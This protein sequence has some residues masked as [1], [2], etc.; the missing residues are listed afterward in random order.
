MKLFNKANGAEGAK[1]EK[2]RSS[3]ALKRGVY[4]TAI[5][6]LFI[7]AV[8]LVNVLTTS[9]SARFPLTIDFSG[10]K[11]NSISE[12][13]AEYLKNVAKPVTIYVCATREEYEQ[14]Y[15]SQYAEYYYSVQDNTGKYY[16]QTLTLLD[17]YPKHNK[18]ITLEF[19]DMSS[20]ENGDIQALFTEQGVNYGDLLVA[21]SFVV[22]GNPVNRYK[23][24]SFSDIYNLTDDSG[25]AAM[26]FGSYGIGGSNLETAL[27]NAIYYATSERIVK[28]GI[29][30]SHCDVNN[31]AYLSDA[32]LA[33]NY[34]LLDLG[35]SLLT[36][37]PEDLDGM[38][39]AAPSKDFG[40]EELD[41]IA[42]FLDNNGKRGKMLLYFAS[43]ASPDLPNL[44]AFLAEWGIQYSDGVLYETNAN[45]AM[46][47]DAT[48]IALANAGSSYTD[49]MNNASGIGYLA[50]GNLPMAQGFEE[51]GS[52][53]TSV[54]LSTSNT[55]VV[56]PSNAG[57]GWKA[58]AS[59]AKSYPAAI[60]CADKNETVTSYVAAFASVSFVNN[61]YANQSTIGN[62]DLTVTLLNTC[63]DAGD[64]VS[65]VSKTIST[66]SFSESVT[67]ASA[68]TIFTLFVVALPLVLIAAGILVWIRRR[69]R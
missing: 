57:D 49:G 37:L 51:Y 44:E 65:F 64:S 39:I 62:L 9:L 24:V 30:T 20:S 47:D 10:D 2:L 48:F 50:Q 27:T 59:A 60:V 32:L 26:G 35:A 31:I 13:N 12:K 16:E 23:R 14:G 58:D 45:Y 5:T 42:K 34:E 33:G 63:F 3:F 7:V 11:I 61:Q 28:L 18:N 68:N 43:H 52:R 8:I 46:P 41:V 4:S 6:A 25:Y 15:L 67:Q 29:P 66:D 56:R 19:V 55:V 69:S 21:S 1:K 22:N 36:D 54:V 38:I 53:T 40:N 17:E